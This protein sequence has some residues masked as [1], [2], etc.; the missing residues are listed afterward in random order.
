MMWERLLT[1]RFNYNYVTWE[2]SWTQ[3]C[4]HAHTHTPAIQVHMEHVQGPREKTLQE[5]NHF[6]QDE[7]IISR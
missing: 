2:C 6:D 7:N 4:A 3:K 5:S 1:I